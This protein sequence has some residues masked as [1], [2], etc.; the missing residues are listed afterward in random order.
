[1]SIDGSNAEL[2]CTGRSGAGDCAVG[3]AGLSIA[4]MQNMLWADMAYA[5]IGNVT[6]ES[7][8]QAGRVHG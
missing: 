3:A 7:N 5:V 1:L 8:Y 6:I 2:G 4:K